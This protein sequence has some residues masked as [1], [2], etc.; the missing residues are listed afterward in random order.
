MSH[1][2]VLQLLRAAENLLG[3]PVWVPQLLEELNKLTRVPVTV[4]EQQYTKEVSYS[5]QQGENDLFFVNVRK[6]TGAAT[7]HV[8][9]KSI[10]FR[11]VPKLKEVLKAVTPRLV[12]EAP[13]K[14]DTSKA[15][16]TFRWEQEDKESLF[17]TF[18]GFKVFIRGYNFKALEGKSERNITPQDKANV[19]KEAFEVFGDEIL[20]YAK[21]VSF[22]LSDVRHDNVSEIDVYHSDGK[23]PMVVLFLI[24]E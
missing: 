3:K 16:I 14:P 22:K 17:D 12:K 10:A 1:R 5:F 18:D 24:E 15:T 7:F 11:S 19:S 21:K 20:T 23:Q 8:A 2:E 6:N 9:G 13:A 4:S